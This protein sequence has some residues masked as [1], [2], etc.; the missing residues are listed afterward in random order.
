MQF[1]K[2]QLFL[3]IFIMIGSGQVIFEFLQFDFWAHIFKALI[4]PALAGYFLSRNTAGNGAL[5]VVALM[6]AWLGDL[7]LI[8]VDQGYFLMG[9]ASF[10][11]MQVLYIIVYF[12]KGVNFEKA[13][14]T[15]VLLTTALL[16]ASA[17]PLWMVL[18]NCG[19]LAPIVGVYGIVLL[20]MGMTAIFRLGSTNLSSFIYT[21]TGAFLFIM[22]DGIIAYS[23][24]VTPLNANFLVMLTYIS[25]QGLIIHGLLKHVKFQKIPA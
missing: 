9:M 2:G 6:L 17:Y 21:G 25:A 3:I 24:F 20:L 7:L 16:G 12:K 8:K 13:M 1:N 18:I 19:A 5:I 15:K 22:S 10:F 4:I 11:G 14:A 23:R